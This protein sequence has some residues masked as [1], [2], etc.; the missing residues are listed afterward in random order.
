MEILALVFGVAVVA[1]SPLVPGLRPL[2]KGLVV[3]GLAVADMAKT[4]AAAAAEQWQDM[5]AEAQAE[6][7]AEATA[8]AGTVETIDIP[9][10]TE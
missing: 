6:R 3:G 2:A 10:P 7:D 5:L 9:L 4:A 1:V 8:R